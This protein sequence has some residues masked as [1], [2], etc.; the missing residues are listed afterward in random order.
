MKS[1]KIQEL[2]NMMGT[3]AENCITL[4]DIGLAML[5]KLNMSSFHIPVDV[6]NKFAKNNIILQY[7]VDEDGN[8]LAWAEQTEKGDNNECNKECGKCTGECSK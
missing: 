2:E 8:I 3:L 6:V 7:K 1:N 5:A 4:N